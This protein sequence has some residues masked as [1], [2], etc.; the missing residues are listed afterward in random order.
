[1]T[2]A[3]LPIANVGGDSAQSILAEGFSEDLAT[4][5]VRVPW[6]RV[7]SR[8]GASNYTGKERHRS[9]GRRQGVRCAVSGDGIAPRDQRP[10]DVHH[11]TRQSRRTVGGLGRQVR[12]PAE[13]GALE[14][15]DRR[16]DRRQPQAKG[17]TILRAGGSRTLPARYRPNVDAC[18]RLYPGQPRAEPAKPGPRGQHR[19]FPAGGEHDSLCADAW[20]G[21][22]LALALSPN[23][24]GASADSVRS[25]VIASARRA[26]QLDPQ[27]AK[28]HMALG[29]VLRAQPRMG[30]GRGGAQDRGRDRSA[31][32]G[33]AGPVRTNP[34]VP[35]QACGRPSRA[36][37][38]RERRSRIRPGI[39]LAVLFVVCCAANWTAPW[40]RVTAR[41]RPIRPT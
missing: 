18:D 26:L 11:A 7:M 27:L 20:S 3:V 15:P 41:C 12:R 40:S 34:H 31:R 23:Y 5:L 8:Q 13:L 28:P 38:A 6:V 35:K 16:D 14:R 10:A 36:Q 33:G 2:V 21:L 29:L 17:G 9:A 32:R 37:K 19:S 1:M 24:R 30:C 4:A 22:S 25:E 39:E